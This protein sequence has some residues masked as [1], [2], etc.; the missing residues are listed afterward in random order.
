MRLKANTAFGSMSRKKPPFTKDADLLPVFRAA[1]LEYASAGYRGATN[2]IAEVLEA[3]S[4]RVYIDPVNFAGASAILD[5][6][7]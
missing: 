1:R 2:R 3:Q 5:D 7:D 6:K 4:K